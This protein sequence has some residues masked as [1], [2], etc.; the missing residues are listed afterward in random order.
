MLIALDVK[1]YFLSRLHKIGLFSSSWR[2]YFSTEKLLAGRR[3]LLFRS[4]CELAELNRRR[5][6]KYTTSYIIE[7]SRMP[8]V[9]LNI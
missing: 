9:I 4:I 5:E 3:V 1:Y 8:V 6:T 7:A 2:K